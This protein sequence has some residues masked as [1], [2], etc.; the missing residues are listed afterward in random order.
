MIPGMI[1]LVAYA[2]FCTAAYLSDPWAGAIFVFMGLVGVA[3][4]GFLVR[5][6]RRLVRG[7]R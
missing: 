2:V 1:L 4:A 6:N 7:S 3:A 5:E